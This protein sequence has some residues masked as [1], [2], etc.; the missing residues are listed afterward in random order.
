M[1]EISRLKHT[2]EA[3]VAALK[4][5]FGLSDEMI[6]ATTGVSRCES[7]GSVT[8]ASEPLSADSGRLTVIL[9]SSRGEDEEEEEEEEEEN[10]PTVTQFIRESLGTSY[11][12][13]PMAAVVTEN[14]HESQVFDAQHIRELTE[15]KTIR[16]N[17]QFVAIGAQVSGP[18]YEEQIS[19]A[20]LHC[21]PNICMRGWRC[22]ESLVSCKKRVATPRAP[23]L[24]RTASVT[25]FVSFIERREEITHEFGIQPKSPS[26]QRMWGVACAFF[27]KTKRG[28]ERTST[29]VLKGQ[30]ELWAQK[31]RLLLRDQA[32]PLGIF[33]LAAIYMGLISVDKVERVRGMETP[34][35]YLDLAADCEFKRDLLKDVDE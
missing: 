30:A 29:I 22:F 3:D 31:S 16:R 15:T 9:S 19:A 23:P 35:I 8:S 27:E 34:D 4:K 6:K 20:L 11:G 21:E 13:G 12:G 25:R 28:Q 26:D 33:I 24:R 18:S 5:E 17:Q 7:L 10:Q 2:L 32:L 14:M 1:S